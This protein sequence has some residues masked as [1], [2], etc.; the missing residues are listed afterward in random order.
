VPGNRRAVPVAVDGRLVGMVTLTDIRG[1]DVA[2]RGS[3]RVGDIMGG[4][5]G[6]TTAGPGT[7]VDEALKQ[8]VEGG[9]EQVPV[10]DGGRLIGMLTLAD[11]AN[12]MQLREALGLA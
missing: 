11:V 3:T 5:N 6:V 9:F 12:Q 4:R 2:A 8:M 7:R 10:L 1:I